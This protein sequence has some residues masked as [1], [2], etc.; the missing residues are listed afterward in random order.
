MQ[1]LISA[2][3][4][5]LIF[6]QALS[7]VTQSK[8]PHSPVSTPSNSTLPKYLLGAT[9]TLCNGDIYD[10]GL[11]EAS[12]IS[13]YESISPDR[14]WMEVGSRGGPVHFAINLPY[15][16]VSGMYSPRRL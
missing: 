7:L 8:P 13:A 9:R 2:F 6:N 1:L 11:G 15:R 4:F 12:C 10:R 16:W 3:T 14:Q 5:S